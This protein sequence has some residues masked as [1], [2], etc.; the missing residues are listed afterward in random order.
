[1]IVLE[2]STSVISS[3]G[4]IIA[5]LSTYHFWSFETF[6][7]QQEKIPAAFQETYY[8]LSKCLSTDSDTVIKENGNVVNC[9]LSHKLQLEKISK[10]TFNVITQ[11][12]YSE[13]VKLILK[14]KP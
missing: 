6:F 13:Y 14:I 1:M 8:S 2:H 3:V 7:G 11:E 9:F 10:E 4:I 12:S 5:I